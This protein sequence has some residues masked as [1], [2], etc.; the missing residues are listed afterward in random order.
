ML[1]A[2]QD[3]KNLRDLDPESLE[4][5]GFTR[6][7]PDDIPLISADIFSFAKDENSVLKLDP[8]KLHGPCLAHVVKNTISACVRNAE[9]GSAVDRVRAAAKLWQYVFFGF[10]GASRAARFSCSTRR[11]C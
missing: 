6:V 7:I 11:T 5:I 8:R 4:E 2:V 9:E 3:A 10:S 1:D